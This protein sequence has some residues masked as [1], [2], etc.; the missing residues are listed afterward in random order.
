MAQG[1]KGVEKWLVVSVEAVVSGWWSMVSEK[2][3]MAGGA[4]QAPVSV[5]RNS[6]ANSQKRSETT[7]Y[8]LLDV[9]RFNY[10]F[11]FTLSTRLC[12]LLH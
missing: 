6:G 11:H 7:W 5:W 2:K 1:E 3:Y 8:G 9:C 12:H 10:N 4:R